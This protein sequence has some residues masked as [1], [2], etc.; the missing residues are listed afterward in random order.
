MTKK[1]R[2]MAGRIFV[3]CNTVFMILFVI[4]TLYPALNILA[5]S[6][7]DGTDALRGAFICGRGDGRSRTMR[8]CLVW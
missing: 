4:I 6:F 7:N 8:Q 5:A 2:S 1:K 3:V